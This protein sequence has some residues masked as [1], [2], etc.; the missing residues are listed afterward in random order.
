MTAMRRPVLLAFAILALAT[1]S[2]LATV[3]DWVDTEGAQVRLVT[4]GKPDA[5]GILHGALEIALQPGWKTYWRDPGDAGVPPQLDVSNSVNVAAAELDFPAPE[6][7]DDGLTKWA[8]Y[9]HPV[10]FPV[11]FTLKATGQPAMIEADIFLGVCQEICVPLQARLTLDPAS[12]PDNADDVALVEAARA[13][14]PAADRPDFRATLAGDD[15]KALTIRAAVPD[16]TASAEIF[17][18]GSGGYMFGSPVRKVSDREIVFSLPVLDRP[19]ERPAGAGL[20][21]TLSTPGGAV[22]GLLPFP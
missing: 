9:G 6:R 5:A 18:A 8:G 16:G 14:L 4:A 10:S 22:E 7:F 12:D 11:T 21:Y 13:R 15:G 20:P 3:S 17:I 1:Q 19:K 2:A